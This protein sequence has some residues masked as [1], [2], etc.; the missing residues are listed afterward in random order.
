MWGDAVDGEF[1]CEFC[2]RS[3]FIFPAMTGLTIGSMMAVVLSDSG[4]APA[5]CSNRRARRMVGIFGAS[6]SGL[7]SSGGV[8]LNFSGVMSRLVGDLSPSSCRLNACCIVSPLF[9]GGVGSFFFRPRL[10]FL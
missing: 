6:G 8:I 9:G 5:S 3:R 2:A 7:L 4:T 1:G 10:S